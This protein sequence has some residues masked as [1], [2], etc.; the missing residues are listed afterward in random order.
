LLRRR[1][2]S[3]P[4]YAALVEHLDEN[5]GR[6]M[7]TLERLGIDRD[8]V[9][10]FV[11]DNGGLAT[12]EGSP[13]SNAPLAEGKGWVYEGGTREPLAVVWPGVIPAGVVSDAITTSTDYYPTL[14]D[15][16]GLAPEP[17]RHVDGVSLAPLLRGEAAAVD[18]EGIFW[19]YPHYGNQGG[20]PACAMR[21]GDF[22]LIEFFEDGRLELYN[23]REDE[24][25]RRNLAAAQ[26][27]LTMALHAR[28]VAWRESLEARIPAINVDY[29]GFAPTTR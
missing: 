26:P 14:L 27:G 4:T 28:L 22:K 21:S 29:P 11:S 19:H 6:L 24:G 8:T 15:L 17:A 5:V 25:E 10:I 2:Q 3:D 12:A 9:V 1:F 23:L 18:R 20:T 13:T 7:A 16:A